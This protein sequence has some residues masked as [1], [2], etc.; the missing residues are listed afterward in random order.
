MHIKTIRR[1]ATLAI[2]L[3]ALT[4]IVVTAIVCITYMF[5]TEHA[6]SVS[7]LLLTCLWAVPFLI[8]SGSSLLIGSVFH[9]GPKVKM[10]LF[11]VS[12]ST[13]VIGILA[14]VLWI[15]TSLSS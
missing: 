6:Y 3:L 11:I 13:S 2:C 5:F 12:F 1:A 4:P 7:E 9:I 10:A 8:S 15:M 14:M